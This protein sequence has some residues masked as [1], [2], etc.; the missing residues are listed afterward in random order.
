M[1]SNRFI[2]SI[3]IICF[4]SL[5]LALLIVVFTPQ[6]AGYEI[7]IYDAY[8]PLVWFF[9]LAGIISG[10][11]I[12]VLISLDD[13]EN[14]FWI[15]GYTG[16]IL[17]NI[18]ILLLPFLRSYLTYGT[19]DVLTHIGIVKDIIATGSFGN[20]LNQ[21]QNVYPVLHVFLAVTGLTTGSGIELLAM[22]VPVFFML[23][24]IF[25]IYLLARVI[26]KNYGEILLITVFGSIL[27][28]KGESL[29]IA[30]SVQAFYLLPFILYLYYKIKKS[31]T[32]IKSYVLCIIG[33]MILMP[34]F[35]PGEGTLLLL[36]ILVLIDIPDFLNIIVHWNKHQITNRLKNSMMISTVTYCLLFI[37]WIE[38]FGN[39]Y[40]FYSQ[41]YKLVSSSIY[42]STAVVY[43]QTATKANLS[44]MQFAD[45]L[46]KM[47]GQH[48]IY[49][50]LAILLAVVLI[51]AF[52]KRDMK[53]IKIE[54]VL[55]FSIFMALMVL[56]FFIDIS[57]AYNR[58]MRYTVFSSTFI[59]GT[60]IYVV[61]KKF[62]HKKILSVFV[63]T[64]LAISA[65]LS[66][67]NIYTSPLLKT[68]NQQVTK[69]EYAGVSWTLDNRIGGLPIE[70]TAP[71]D[72]I[73]LIHGDYGRNYL[74]DNI[75]G[76]N[77]VTNHFNYTNSPNKSFAESIGQDAYFIEDKANTIYY[78]NV[79]PEYEQYWRFT[80]EDY[81]WLNHNDVSVNQ[82]YSNGEEWTYYVSYSN[83]EEWTYYVSYLNEFER[84]SR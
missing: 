72:L 27:L 45:M 26:T 15:F 19:G 65:M 30:P 54:Y 64:I 53:F 3:S 12:V 52:I 84:F 71:A 67:F 57:L 5:L 21:P 82:I 28:F 7:S 32:N 43:S 8:N 37:V 23:F 75:V 56:A 74:Y 77:Y 18:L 47:N 34:L 83:G 11:T 81:E 1:V 51:I 40:L 16:I 70:S 39:L 24:Y 14:K 76:L 29:M 36:L 55:M 63:I 80:P 10:I 38:W 4:I 59:L 46:L 60:G 58:E 31:T 2:K 61:R 35:H 33:F 22:I 50:S 44:V 49:F 62:G 42:V 17:S 25:S 6:A 48:L 41:I 78:Q 69:M 73:R 13:R 66:L 9:L 79:I 20:E 68:S